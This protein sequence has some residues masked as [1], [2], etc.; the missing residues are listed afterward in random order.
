MP[1]HLVLFKAVNMLCGL[2][3]ANYIAPFIMPFFPPLVFIYIV[4]SIIRGAISK[5]LSVGKSFRKTFLWYYLPAIVISYFI[6]DS[7]CGWAGSM[8]A[9][10]F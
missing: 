10:L 7:L 2:P 8:D 6:F 5:K 1:I 3:Y 4:V 9:G